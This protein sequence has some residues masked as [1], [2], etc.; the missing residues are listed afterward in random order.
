LSHKPK[1]YEWATFYKNTP[2]DLYSSNDYA[3]AKTPSFKPSNST[4]KMVTPSYSS[5]VRAHDDENA[6]SMFGPKIE[7]QEDSSRLSDFLKSFSLFNQ[8]SLLLTC[9]KTPE[10]FLSSTQEGSTTIDMTLGL[11]AVSLAS[12]TIASTTVLDMH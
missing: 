3:S 9:E 12:D 6:K 10:Q 8:D 11:S 7:K 2:N 4:Q 1:Q 5:F